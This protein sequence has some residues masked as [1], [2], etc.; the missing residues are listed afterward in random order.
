MRLSRRNLI[1]L[2][3]AAGTALSFPSILRAQTAATAEHTVSMV[4]S[5]P[6]TA[7]DPFFTTSGT[8]QNHSLAIYDTLFALD[9]K[10]LPRP[11]MVGNWDISED[12]KIYTFE[13]RGGLGWHDG[14][15]VTAGDCVASV[16]RWGQTSAGQTFS[17]RVRDISKKDEKTFTIV[18]NEPTGVLI[19]LMATLAG[20]SLFM[21]REKD[22][23]RPVTEQVTS[24]IGSGPFKF[25][26]SLARPGASFAYDRNE[27]YVA[28]NEPTNGFAGSKVVKV[29]RV[30]WQS[31]ADVQTAF[32]ALQTGEIDFLA[33]PPGDLYSVIESDPNLSLQVLDKA[34]SD[35]C[36]RMNHLQKP[37]N[38]V[39]ARQAL[40]H[41]I[42][43]E[44]FLRVTAPDPR[45]G[46]P[47]TSIFGNSTPY[48]NDENTGWYKK[49]GD[50]EKAKQLFQEAGYAGEKV[51]ILDPTDWPR[52]DAASQLLA[53]TLQKIGINAELASSDWGG[54]VKRRANKGPVESGGWN[55]FITDDGDYVQGD[56]LTALFLNA[57]GDKAWFGW[58]HNDEYEALRAKW[59]DVGTLEERK[60]LARDMQR[61]FWSFVGDVRLGQTVSPVARRKTLTELIEMPQRLAMWNM[62]KA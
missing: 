31:M 48:S 24:N 45:Y 52:G 44:A 38:N 57:S 22:A 2:G 62:Q 1:K 15:P 20:N 60:A 41:L 37:F 16:R 61:V 25:N 18:L 54:I 36:L 58:P 32:A 43:Q 34:G 33:S 28:R 10:L 53:N 46:R 27:K 14:S 8:T 26:E 49:G 47:V 50:P 13:L 59:V 5:D 21:M 29:D 12:K 6:L 40:L 4:L 51:V 56:P 30:V 55:I 3:A 7:F 19:D 17:A 35:M 23:E 39:K 42:D 9:S 11:Q